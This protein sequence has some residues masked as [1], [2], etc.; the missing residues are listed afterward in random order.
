MNGENFN[1][2]PDKTSNKTVKDLIEKLSK[3]WGFDNATDSYSVKHTEDFH[4]AGLLQ[5]DCSK[6]NEKL[7]WQPNLSFDEMVNFS[8]DWYKKFYTS[9]NNE[10]MLLQVEEQIKKYVDLAKNKKISWAE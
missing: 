1:F 4:E 3:R 9:N 5:L 2:G 8:S 7:D 10:E 6:A